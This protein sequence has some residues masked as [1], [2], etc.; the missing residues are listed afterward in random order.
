MTF[1]EKATRVL[2]KTTE[3]LGS[4]QAVAGAILVVVVWACTGPLMGYSNT[5]QLLINTGTTISTGIMV[6]IL[7]FT[8]NRGDRASQAKQDLVLRQNSW[9]IKNLHP[10][11]VGELLIHEAEVLVGIE[12]E[13]SKKIKVEQEQI[14]S[15]Q[16][17]D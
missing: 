5:W 8:E 4:L 11:E 17:K 14:R 6:F 13:T 12:D 16:I 2:D 7:L 15:N 1:M 10:D 9:L 3:G